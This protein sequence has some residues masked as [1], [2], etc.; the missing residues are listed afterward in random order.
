MRMLR[1]LVIAALALAAEACNRTATN[2]VPDPLPCTA[3]SGSP[4]T[5]TS[6][7]RRLEKPVPGLVREPTGP[8]KNLGIRI[9][10]IR[11]T[12]AGRMVDMRFM[13][14]DPEKA[15]A[16]LSKDAKLTLIDESTGVRSNVPST[17]KV[18]SLRQKTTVP[19]EGRGYFALFFNPGNVFKPGRKV[20]LA[21]GD[22]RVEG[23]VVT[24]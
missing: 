7:N 6:G 10:S 8:E 12:G 11:Q 21:A 9:L 5:G 4:Q 23:L 16:I 2:G 15:T 24:D 18:G 20:T 22:V 13:V 14:S 19:E 3:I 17:P 1:I